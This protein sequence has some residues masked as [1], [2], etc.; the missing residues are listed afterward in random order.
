MPTVF[1]TY[2]TNTPSPLDSSKTVE[3][4]LWDTAGACFV[5]HSSDCGLSC[6]ARGLLAGNRTDLPRRLAL[7]VE[8]I[9]LIASSLRPKPRIAG[10]GC[11]DQRPIKLTHAQV[12]RSLIDYDR[13]RTPTSA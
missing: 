2:V 3:L 1:E 9:L 13:S 8:H 12:R 4:A 11:R 10:F 5:E 7:Q 6:S